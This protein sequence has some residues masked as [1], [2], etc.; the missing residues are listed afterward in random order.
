MLYN[1]PYKSIKPFKRPDLPAI[2]GICRFWFTEISNL[3]AFPYL[4]PISQTFTFEPPL[5]TGAQWFAALVPDRSRGW[6][7]TQETSTAGTYYKE[8]VEGFLPGNDWENHITLANMAGQQFCIIAK[9][10]SSSKYI[11]LGNQIRGLQLDQAATSG[12]GAMDTPGTKIS[13]KIDAAYKA[14]LL[15]SFS[16]DINRTAAPTTQIFEIQFSNLFE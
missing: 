10:R 4:D 2:G 16:L 15:D 5:K 6:N 9:L 11:I 8:T 7:E 14:P 3:A 12:T 1:N 13:F